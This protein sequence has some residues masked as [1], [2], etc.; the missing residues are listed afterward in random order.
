ML[1]DLFAPRRRPIP[2]LRAA[3]ERA[4]AY[5]I[6]VGVAANLS[7]ASDK[8]VRIADLVKNL[9][10]A[11]VPEDVGSRSCGA[12]AAE[13]AAAEGLRGGAGLPPPPS[14]PLLFPSVSLLQRPRLINQSF[15]NAPHRP[16]LEGRACVIRQAFEEFR[17]RSGS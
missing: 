8:P 14:P 5:S 10:R 6:L 16:R 17:S 1:L 3:D 15:E 12:D 7:M 2:S 13:G 4:G 9:E 11:D